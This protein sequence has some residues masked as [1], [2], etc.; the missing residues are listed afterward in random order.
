[1]TYDMIYKVASIGAE[2]NQFFCFMG[3]FTSLNIFNIL[4]WNKSK[5][6]KQNLQ[7]NKFKKTSNNFVSMSG[8]KTQLLIF[9]LTHLNLTSMTF[10]KFYFSKNVKAKQ[11]KLVKMPSLPCSNPSEISLKAPFF[12][13]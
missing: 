11:F 12:L 6:K 1:M 3:N 8:Q 4:E 5:A 13:T 10:S 7:K 2:W 9:I